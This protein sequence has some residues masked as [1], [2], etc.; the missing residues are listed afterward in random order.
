VG[1]FSNGVDEIGFTAAMIDALAVEYTVDQSRVYA[2]GYSN[3]AN[4]AWELACLLSDRITAVGA[5]AGSMWT[6]TETLCSPTRPVSVLSIHGTLDFYNPYEGGPPFS[7]GPIAASEYWVQIDGADAT[8]TVVDV[9]DTV[10]GD[11]STVDHYTWANGVNCV[12]VE[13]YKV[14][15]GGHD[16]PGSFGNMDID[17]NQ[18]I[19]DF[20]SQYDLD[21]KID[22]PDD[23]PDD[24][25]DDGVADT[26]DNCIDVANA[27]QRDADNDG[28]GSVCDGDLNQDCLVSRIDLQIFRNRLGTSDPRADYDGDGIVGISDFLLMRPQLGSPPGPS[29][30]DNACN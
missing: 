13:H 18:E 28:I 23:P 7:L 5:V 14:V 3:G 26:A 17:S 22:C 24:A 10:P 25:D 12:A 6:W 2:S 9:P 15:G 8:P 29:G 21:G 19:W 1:P 4:M 16:W 20:V 30:I 11:G 27:D